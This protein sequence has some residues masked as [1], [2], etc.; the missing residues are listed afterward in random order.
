[1]AVRHAQNGEVVSLPLADRLG[2]TATTTLVKTPQLELI[3]LVV[4]K[5]KEIPPHRVPGPI[6][7]QCLEGRVQLIA[8][9]KQHELAPGQLVY[10]A[11][12]EPHALRGLDNSSVLVTIVQTPRQ[13]E[14]LDVVD[15]ASEES[16]PASDAPAY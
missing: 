13:R 7:I 15:E 6:T 4:P 10:L 14:K 11:G 16:F 9:E 5:G 12:G 1:M 2:S 3:R 8:Q